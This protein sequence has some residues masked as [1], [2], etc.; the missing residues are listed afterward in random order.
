MFKPRR[1]SQR[2]P[3]VIDDRR[4]STTVMKDEPG[5]IALVTE[6]NQELSEEYRR[7]LDDYQQIKVNYEIVEGKYQDTQKENVKVKRHMEL[8]E[9]KFNREK[10]VLVKQKDDLNV[11]S[12]KLRKELRE[13]SSKVCINSPEGAHHNVPY[14]RLRQ[15]R[16]PPPPPIRFVKELSFDAREIISVRLHTW[17]GGGGG[18]GPYNGL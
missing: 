6:K 17:A 5:S 12:E 7:L 10:T 2:A 18:W 15:K 8:N 9:E 14:R 3:P 11:Q 13:K 4:T 1:S 16:V